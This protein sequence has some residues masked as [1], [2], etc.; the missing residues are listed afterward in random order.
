MERNPAR[1]VGGLALLVAVWVAAY[2]LWTPTSSVTWAERTPPLAEPARAGGG[3][4]IAQHPRANPAPSPNPVV[5]PAKPGPAADEPARV[6]RRVAPPEAV[7]Y[8]VQK[9]ETLESIAQRFY[10][11]RSKWRV[12]A[13][14]NPM[15][16]PTRLRPG[17]VVLVP[18]DADHAKGRP[19]VVE[20]S[21]SRVEKDDKTKP[22]AGWTEYVVGKGDS[23]SKISRMVYGTPKHADHI[24]DA[25]RGVLESPDRVR[26]GQ[27]LRIPPAPED[28]AR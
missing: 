16:D 17:R 27:K 1:L 19:V 11:D 24:F 26:V 25:N 7:Q 10:G 9:N 28:S 22:A 3:S 20:S 23:L 21:S 6:E 15:L 18:K 13:E 2:W 4:P 8:Q 14:A 12:I 5:A